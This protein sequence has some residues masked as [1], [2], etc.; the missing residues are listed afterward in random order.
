MSVTFVETAESRTPDGDG[1]LGVPFRH[2]Q[3][4]GAIGQAA[5]GG[6]HDGGPMPPEAPRDPKPGDD[7]G[8]KVTT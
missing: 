1:W 6:K 5:D 4:L 3:D 2:P 8:D 7:D